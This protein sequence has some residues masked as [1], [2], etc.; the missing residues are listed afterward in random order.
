MITS[1]NCYEDET[2]HIHP[3]TGLINNAIKSMTHNSTDV[4]TYLKQIDR[5]FQQT[6]ATQTEIPPS[7]LR[8][9]A[10]SWVDQ[11][12]LSRVDVDLY[13]PYYFRSY[14]YSQIIQL[15]FRH[16]TFY[17]LRDLKSQKGKYLESF[18]TKAIMYNSINTVDML[19]FEWIDNPNQVISGSN[20][21]TIALKF[22]K[23]EIS[24]MLHSKYGCLL[25]EFTDAEGVR[26]DKQLIAPS[27]TQIISSKNHIS[28]FEKIQCMSKA[29]YEYD[30]N[31]VPNI[32]NSICMTPLTSAFSEDILVSQYL[33]ET[34]LKRGLYVD[35]TELIGTAIHSFLNIN[36]KF[37]ILDYL[38]TKVDLQD[39]SDVEDALIDHI[40]YS[41]MFD[42]S[43]SEIIAIL[44]WL[45]AHNI[46]LSEYK[47]Q[48]AAI[49]HNRYDFIDEIRFSEV[50]FLIE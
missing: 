5:Y 23:L 45:N 49:Q 32:E 9:I 22:G 4:F 17:L 35:Y 2:Q 33:L 20:L 39:I 40:R 38:A 26:V 44:I 16:L 31:I 48:K 12:I 27:L 1:F 30:V 42:N 50:E 18:I 46:F 8:A 24:D 3:L 41:L 36:E 21:L 7:D 29:I 14:I 47:L 19:M 28:T 10:D 34:A 13:F 11:D 43:S 15:D 6:P 25:D 37:K